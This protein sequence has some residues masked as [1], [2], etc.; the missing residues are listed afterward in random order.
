MRYL[1]SLISEQTIPNLLFIHSTKDI[2]VYVFVNTAKTRDEGR[3]EWIASMCPQ[4]KDLRYITTSETS[5]SH[6]VQD[7][8]NFVKSCGAEAEFVVNI[9]CGTKI[10]ALA[11]Y[12]VFSTYKSYIF[13]LPA[14]E[15]TIHQ[16]FPKAVEDWRKVLYR[17]SV[18][19]FLAVY[20]MSIQCPANVLH[21]EDILV[22]MFHYIAESKDAQLQIKINRLG[23]RMDT[24]KKHSPLRSEGSE[25]FARI[26]HIDVADVLLP[27][28]LA[29]IKGAWFEEYLVHFFGRVYPHLDLLANVS[30]SKADVPNELDIAF[31]H[32][33]KLYVMEA[34]AS[35]NSGNMQEFLYK[36]DSIRREFGLFP[37]SFLAVAD[38]SYEA[39]MRNK[40]LLLQRAKAL[41]IRI[42]TH[43]DLQPASIVQTLGSIL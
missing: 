31:T 37:K 12:S 22:A 23:S 18:K 42:L 41:G 33:N 32:E 11:A 43:R 17:I 26:M 14:M 8:Q 21:G 2:D 35:L 36:M 25:D 13:Y 16:L 34:K 1:I 19:D 28:N 6:I 40:V 10:M 20:G 4:I 24:S 7:L 9:T 39:S 5:F 3:G 29:F 15:N 30:I 38:K 27:H